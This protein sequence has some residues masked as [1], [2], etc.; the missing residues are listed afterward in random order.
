MTQ[1]LCIKASPRGDQSAANQA[2]SVFLGEL[3]DGVVVTQI[4]LSERK[5]PDV[6]LE[7]SQA[8]MKSFMGMELTDEE[9]RQWSAITA[10]ADE[11]LGADHYLFAIPM[12]NFSIPYTFKHYIDAINHPGITFT[13]DDKGPRGLASGAATII[14]S[15]GGDYAPKDGKPDPL[16]FQ[17]TYVKA[18]LQT[19]GISDVKEILVQNTMMGPDAVAA[20]ISKATDDLTSAAQSVGG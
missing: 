5:L 13:R 10:L 19:I 1:L 7:V 8:K 11:F 18:W 4:D 16:D 20:A 17:S 3:P 15:R 2:A 12:W 9:A 6:T 14:Y